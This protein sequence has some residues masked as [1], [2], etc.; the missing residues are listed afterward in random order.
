MHV[1]TA[2]VNVS[3]ARQLYSQLFDIYGQSNAT[4]ILSNADVT[5]AF[6]TNNWDT[7]TELSRK[8]GERDVNDG[9]HTSREPLITQSQLAAMETGQALIIISGSTK[10]ITWLPDYREMYDFSSWTPP[11]K[12]GI[13]TN[14]TVS[15]FNISEYVK[16]ARKNKMEAILGG[17][18]IS[19]ASNISDRM[20]EPVGD[21]EIQMDDL[22]ARI[23]AKIAALEAEEAE[24]KKKAKKTYRVIV[25]DYGKE[26]ISVAA[27]ISSA[28]DLTV[29]QASKRLKKLPAEF[30]FDTKKEAD[31]VKILVE[32]A[33][34]S[35]TIKR[36]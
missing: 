13:A 7:L 34:G 23:D 32:N 21:M 6:R 14:S 12:R 18:G 1:K 36:E 20:P 35:A 31:K 17:N 15:T 9:N 2:D 11:K 24:E 3:R 8:C 26:L 30:S 29:V 28:S 16:D 22:V 10:F 4:T 25:S 33:G 19:H 27:A 5:M